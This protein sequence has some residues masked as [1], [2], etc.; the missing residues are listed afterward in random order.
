MNTDPFIFSFSVCLIRCKLTLLLNGIP[1]SWLRSHVTFCSLYFYHGLPSAIRRWS[2][3]VH[4]RMTSSL[5]LCVRVLVLRYRSGITPYSFADLNQRMLQ[6]YVREPFQF[7]C[8]THPLLNWQPLLQSSHTWPFLERD[9][10]WFQEKNW[11]SI[12]R[13]VL[14]AGWDFWSDGCL[15]DEAG[16]MILLGVGHVPVTHS[17][18]ARVYFLY[19]P[20]RGIIS[21][22][23]EHERW[24]FRICW[25]GEECLEAGLISPD[26]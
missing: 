17:D 4:S 3:A 21:Q 1:R 6:C 8:S 11:C 22:G 14:F 9:L 12:N 18:I 13:Q 23:W 19:C 5:S 24:M 2:P 16:S 7:Y 25:A 26:R 15:I 20:R 10:A